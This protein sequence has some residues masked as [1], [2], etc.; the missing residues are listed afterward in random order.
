M[1]VEFEYRDPSLTIEELAVKAGCQPSAVREAIELYGPQF[2]NMDGELLYRGSQSQFAGMTI[3]EWC[4]TTHLKEIKPHWF[5]AD[6]IQSL[7]EAAFGG[8][9]NK[10]NLAAR[11]QLVREV[12]QALYDDLMRRWGA[13]HTTNGVRPGPEPKKDEKP[14]SPESKATQ[15]NPWSA[16]NWNI[17][18]QGEIVKALGLAKAQGIAKAAGSY[19][20]ATK[21]AT[22][23]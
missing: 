21:P 10:P 11:G 20:G 13:S 15:N 9:K 4:A 18:R 19:I 1:P 12:G 8:P 5:F 22:A 6:E 7:E 2:K 14:R 23:H 3:E 16:S 17:T